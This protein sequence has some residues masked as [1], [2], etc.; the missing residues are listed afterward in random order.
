MNKKKNNK[1]N[2][3]DDEDNN[4]NNN[5][6]DNDLVRSGSCKDGRSAGGASC[7]PKRK[8]WLRMRRSKAGGGL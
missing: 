2:N 3:N 8:G 1:K 5:K 6:E 4:N 7:K